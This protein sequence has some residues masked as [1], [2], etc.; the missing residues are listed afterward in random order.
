MKFI[1]SIIMAVGLCATGYSQV[2]DTNT[3]PPT[4]SG[5]FI[6][7]L[8]SL[9]TATNW[10]IATFG[11]YT[12]K[13]DK[14]GKAGL[15]A[16]AVALYNITPYVA[17]GVGID[18]LN[19]DVT[20]PSAQVQFQAPLRIGGTNGVVVRPFAFTGVATPVAGMGDDN[21]NVVGIIGAGLGVKIWKGLNIFYG[22]EQRTGQPAPWQLFGAA[23]SISF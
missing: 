18:W 13:T 12:P 14:P 22:I 9:S 6:D 21:G 10:G 20:M 4:L 3:S 2:L 11:I 5:P 23:Y 8:G 17:T 1:L 7:M 19:D 15:G 16:G